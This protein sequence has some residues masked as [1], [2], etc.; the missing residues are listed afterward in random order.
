VKNSY[1]NCILGVSLTIEKQMKCLKGDNELKLGSFYSEIQH[2]KKK[3]LSKKKEDKKA[4]I[5]F[6]KIDE[7]QHQLKCDEIDYVK[8]YGQYC[9]IHYQ[10]NG[11]LT[12]E[13]LYAIEEFL[14]F[15]DFLRVHKFYAVSVPK[16]HSVSG[17]LVELANTKIPIGQFYR[18]SFKKLMK[19]KSCI[20]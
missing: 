10:G 18:K 13:G 4:D 7:K 3:Q 17:N 16:I 12:L 9:K 1:E 11:F 8:G 5:F 6:I 19:L 20:Q 15:N 2:V 14:P